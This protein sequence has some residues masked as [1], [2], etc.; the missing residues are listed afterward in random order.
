MATHHIGIVGGGVGG[1]VAALL[2]RKRG[3][4][5]T[6]YEKAP[7]LGGR[8]AYHQHGDDRIDRGPTVVL[9]PEMILSILEQA[10]I[11]RSRINFTLCDPVATIHYSDGSFLRKYRDPSKQLA[12]IERFAPG[13]GASYERFIEALEETYNLSKP[14]FLDRAFRGKRDILSWRH[15]QTMWKAQAHRSVNQLSA[16][17]FQDDRLRHAFSLQTLYIGGAPART[18]ALY[19]L[20]AYAEQA[21]GIWY[22]QGGYGG[23]AEL[24]ATELERAGVNIQLSAGVER[25]LFDGKRC[26]GVEVNGERHNHDYLVYNG[27]FP[28]IASLL[29]DG[30]THV[31]Q[32]YEP[33]SGCV[34]AYLKVNRRWTTL[35]THQ[36][37]LPADFDRQMERIFQQKQLPDD[38]SYYVFHPQSVDLQLAEKDY[39]LLYILIPVPSAK[40]LQWP[41]LAPELVRRVLTD[42][43]ARALPGLLEAIEWCDI[44][45]PL[46]ALHAG[47]YHGGSFGIAPTRLQSGMF[48]PQ[49]TVRPYERL[50]AVGASVHPGGGIPIVMQGARLLD[51]HLAKEMSL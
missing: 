48:R 22:L 44:S 37:Y 45:T 3:C 40:H 9:L 30:A 33:S 41:Q 27:D 10:G 23:L 18:P 31:N 51:E 43:Q 1:M 15:L 47:L 13:Q 16:A 35:D 36:F 2:L 28:T 8:L 46:D 50:Y 29:P 26:V 4:Q 11:D 34:L 5:V 6:I 38:P 19:S 42:L 21:F 24:L 32:S 17:Y 25:L 49:I 20:I 14:V 12:E 39:S 7:K